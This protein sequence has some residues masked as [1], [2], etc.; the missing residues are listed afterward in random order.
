MLYQ[1]E[2]I[3]YCTLPVCSSYSLLL[4]L[5]QFVNDIDFFGLLISDNDMQLI[6]CC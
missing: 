1:H 3:E 2:H 6:H 5:L 4:P